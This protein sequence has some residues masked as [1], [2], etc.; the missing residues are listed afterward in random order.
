MADATTTPVRRA[1]V[2]QCQKCSCEVATRGPRLYCDAC[3]QER[4]RERDRQYKNANIDKN[5]QSA[6]DWHWNNREKAIAGAKARRDA[7][8]EEVRAKDRARHAANPRIRRERAAAW[9]EANREKRLEQNRSDEG[10]RYQRDYERRKRRERPDFRVHANMSASIRKNLRGKG[11]RSWQSLVGYTLE[12]LMAHLE[13]QF[14]KGM[15]W[16]NYGSFWEID[17]IIPRASFNFA[18]TEDE[19]FRQCWSLTNL[20]PLRSEANRRKS[21]QRLHLI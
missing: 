6:R 1:W 2:V 11:G 12:E 18:T 8:I 16:D 5:R 17:H 10:R 21:A 13:R 15:T 3:F 20:R 4:K 7:N 14:L 19:G 9:Y